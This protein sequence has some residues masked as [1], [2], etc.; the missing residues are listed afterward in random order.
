MRNYY[1]FIFVLG[2]CT[3]CAC[4]NP[5][6]PKPK[7]YS[8]LHFPEKKYQ[9]FNEL[10]YPYA[11]EYPIYANISKEVNYFGESKKEDNWININ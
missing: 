5:V 8:Q 11:F 4:N 6:V 9:P 1:Y 3:I 10:G 2:I 7:G